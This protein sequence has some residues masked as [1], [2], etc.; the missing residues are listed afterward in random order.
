MII[1]ILS[2][3]RLVE[4]TLLISSTVPNLKGAPKYSERGK[5]GDK[6]GDPKL[7]WFK[8]IKK[9]LYV[10][11]FQKLNLD[12]EKTMSVFAFIQTNRH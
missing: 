9:R 6:K 2:V 7:E 10:E 11:I 3:K 12:E 4:V 5:K 8:K 1:A